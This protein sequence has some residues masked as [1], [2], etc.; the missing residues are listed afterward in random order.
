MIRQYLQF[1]LF[2]QH[3]RPLFKEDGKTPKTAPKL[4]ISSNCVNLIVAL[5]SAK[6]KKIK[7]GGLKEDYDETPEGYEG[8][9]DAL[10][11]LMVYLFHDKKQ[12]TA[13]L[14]GF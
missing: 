12:F 3:G 8:L 2:D 6:F 13:I 4:F 10:R 11:Y 7:A 14:D 9:I 5:S 1:P